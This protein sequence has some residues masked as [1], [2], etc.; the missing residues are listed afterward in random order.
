[1][2][3]EPFNYSVNDAIFNIGTT[4]E[5]IGMSL[6]DII[7][8]TKEK[9]KN[10]NVRKSVKAVMQPTQSE[11]ERKR[12]LV[13]NTARRSQHFR[14][15]QMQ[16]NRTEGDQVQRTQRLFGQINK[17]LQNKDNQV[18]RTSR[19][20]NNKTARGRRSY[21]VSALARQRALKQNTAK[22]LKV[23]MQRKQP[24]VINNNSNKGNQINKA[25]GK[26]VKISFI[27]SK[28]QTGFKFNNSNNNTPLVTTATSTPKNFV[29]RGRNQSNNSNN[30]TVTNYFTA[31]RQ[32]GRNIGRAANNFNRKNIKE[33]S[34]TQNQNST[35]ARAIN[36][37]RTNRVVAARRNMVVSNPAS[38]TTVEKTLNQRFS[39]N[40]SGGITTGI[41]RLI[42]RK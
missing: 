31:K 5:K 28:A 35:R 4:E 13:Q 2:E 36:Q 24:A 29:F 8:E 6:E 17:I 18:I 3:I 26:E 19:F 41:K 33:F 7:K 9:D 22:L 32:P 1:M 42:I 16:N 38:G 34:G 30:P 15:Q 11:K 23:Q 39:Q 10:K 20:V 25:L 12:L 40:R 27:N 21:T 14:E 37:E